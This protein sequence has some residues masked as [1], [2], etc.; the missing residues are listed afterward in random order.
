MKNIFLFLVVCL[1]TTTQLS[2]QG[3]YAGP[4]LK[5]LIGTRVT[6]E[7]NVK[8]L[9]GWK[10]MEGTLLGFNTEKEAIIDVYK[11]GTTYAVVFRFPQKDSTYRIRDI[12]EIK[13]VPATQQIVVSVCRLNDKEDEEII[14]LVKGDVNTGWYKIYKTWRASKSKELFQS[15]PV[16]SIKCEMQGQD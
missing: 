1:V 10:L 7:K 14:A 12:L 2:A 4:V 11:K 8:G 16:R 6:D 15:I 3:K 13:N 9:N 5:K